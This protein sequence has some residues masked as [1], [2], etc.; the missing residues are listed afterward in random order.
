MEED[1]DIITATEEHRDRIAVFLRQNFYTHEPLNSCS[2]ALPERPANEIKVLQK[3]PEGLSLLAISRSTQRILG[4]CLNEEAKPNADKQPEMTYTHPAYAK[5]A[6]FLKKFADSVD[7]WKI[8]GADRAVFI[9]L[10]AVDAAARG[11]GIG[12]ALMEKTREKARSAGYPLIAVTC[13]SF[14][15]TRIA[16]DMG[17]HSVYCLPYSEYQDEN[18]DPVFKPPLPHTEVNLMVQKLNL[19]TGL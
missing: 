5:I 12:R 18:G 2:G 15:S 6:K 17:M 7:V 14:F 1:Y 3:L 4:V 11:R 10:L 16:R 9:I 19:E 8:T 13:T